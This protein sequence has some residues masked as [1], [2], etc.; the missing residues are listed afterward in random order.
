MV[1]EFK[2]VIAQNCSEYKSLNSLKGEISVYLYGANCINCSNFKNE[3]CTKNLFEA[4]A[5]TI[6]NN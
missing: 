3:K 2:G 5:K 4:I 1:D 6:N